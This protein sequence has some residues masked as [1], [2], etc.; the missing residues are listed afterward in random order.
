MNRCLSLLVA[1]LSMTLVGCKTVWIESTETLDVTAKGLRGIVC[2]T[3][4]GTIELVGD[5]EATEVTVSVR[6][7][8]GGHDAEDAAAAM[9][10]LQ[11]INHTS[12]ARLRL[13]HKWFDGEGGWRAS[14]SFKV[15]YP[16]SLETVA[17]THNGHITIR[18]ARRRCTA[19][20]HNGS[21]DLQ[22]AVARSTLRSENGRIVADLSGGREPAKFDC[23]IATSNG[24]VHLTLDR[25]VSAKLSCAT[26]HGSLRCSLPLRRAAFRRNSIKGILGSGTGKIKIRTRNGSVLLRPRSSTM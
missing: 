16:Q 25:R 1:L 11:V 24:S 19:T 5:P 22:G 15:I 10:S 26:R 6:K 18:G 4:N 12:R 3:R 13:G 9:Q 7:R 20:T 23:D 21:I 17:E 2:E 8:V 14:V